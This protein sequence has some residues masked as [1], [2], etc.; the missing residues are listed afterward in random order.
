MP[1]RTWT[2][3][4]LSSERRRLSGVCWRAVEGQHRVS[5]MKLV[6]TLEEQSVLEQA[7]EL[8]KPPVSPE[9]R[10]LHYLLS[11]PFRYAAPYPSGSRFRRA[12]LTPGI[13]Y[14]SSAPSTAIAEA[15]F[16]RLL[17]FAD[18][19]ATGWPEN[20]GEHTV[21]SVRFRTSAALDLLRQPLSGDR[22][23]WEHRTDYSACQDLAD[24]ARAAEVAVLRYG[25]ARVVGGVNYAL[26]TCK[27][28]ASPKP[29]DR[30]TWRI[31][32]GAGG[33]RAVC[34]FPETRLAFDR[35]AFASDR[36]IASVEW[37]R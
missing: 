3:A 34:E 8:S 4:A 35:Q 7:L 12:G 15:V 2:P 22:E 11:T 25:S 26:L 36:R 27:A 21:F 32:V 28:F 23:R 20:A 30:Q 33:A 6:D 16:H 29:V 17:F 19:P 24:A 18:S 13:F 37:E 5:T 9:C 14:A 10:H 1:S 31:H